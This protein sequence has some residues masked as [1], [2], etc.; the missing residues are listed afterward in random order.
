MTDREKQERLLELLSDRA[1]FELSAED[2][3]ELDDLLSIFP[4]WREDETFEL[5]TAAIAL[6]GLE[7]REEMPAGLKNKIKAD[8]SRDFAGEPLWADK[9]EPIPDS[10]NV[11]RFKTRHYSWS[12][13]LGWAAAAAACIALVVNIWLTRLP[14]GPDIAGPPSIDEPRSVAQLR[15]QMMDT[16]ADITKANWTAGN[17]PEMKDIGGDVVWSDSRQAGYMRLKGLPA[18]DGTK[19]TYQLWIF[20]ETQDPKTPI[21]GGVF[22]VNA[23][24]EAIIP[25]NAKLKARNPKMFAI[26]IEKPGGVVVSDRKKIAALAKVEI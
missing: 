19:E 10:T 4:D 8:W 21:D 24:G 6:S 20:D 26:T 2:R 5:T 1:L 7:V 18:N 15:Q 14:Q 12:G 17:M 23:N 11:I 9:D 16:S 22:N 3:K 13:L 25:I